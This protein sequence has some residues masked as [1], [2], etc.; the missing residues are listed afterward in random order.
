MELEERSAQR[1]PQAGL[2]LMMPSGSAFKPSRQ[3]AGLVGSNPSLPQGW[4]LLS[5][6]PGILRD[7]RV[8]PCTH[9]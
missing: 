5:L 9:R 6:L 2:C 3:V 8:R 7:G 1:L 4:G